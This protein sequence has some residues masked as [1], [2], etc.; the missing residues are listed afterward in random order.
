MASRE[1][2]TV[3]N[4]LWPGTVSAA[5]RRAGLVGEEVLP[6][7]PIRWLGRRGGGEAGAMAGDAGAVGIVRILCG[8]HVEAGCEVHRVHLAFAD[9][10]DEPHRVAVGEHHVE[11]AIGGGLERCDGGCGCG[12][13]AVS[14]RQQGEF[15]AAALAGG[16]AEAA[17]S[18][19]HRGDQAGA[20]DA[21]PCAAAEPVPAGD[22]VRLVRPMGGGGRPN[23]GRGVRRGWRRAAAARHGPAAAG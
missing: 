12:G 21:H 20:V 15:A 14:Q 17:G 5:P 18:V 7:A 11:A 4:P 1:A 22:D 6:G 10:A 13:G 16:G 3:P 2:D 23:C 19:E 8:D 9:V